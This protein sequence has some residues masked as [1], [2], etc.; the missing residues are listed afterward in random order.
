MKFV[1]RKDSFQ[2]VLETSETTA[3]NIHRIELPTATPPKVN[4][5]TF[6]VVVNRRPAKGHKSTEIAFAGSRGDIDKNCSPLQFSINDI[7]RQ[8]VIHSIETNKHAF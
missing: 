2:E 3:F 5:H 7:C 6:P 8:E 4:I 1:E